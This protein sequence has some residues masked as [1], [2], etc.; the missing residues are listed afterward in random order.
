VFEGRRYVYHRGQWYD[1]GGE[2]LARLHGKIGRILSHRF[3]YALPTWPVTQKLR[4]RTNV[5]YT[6]PVVE[7]HYNLLAA[8]RSNGELVCLDKKLIR[9]EQHPHGIESCDLLGPKNE[10]IHVKRLDDSVSASH[11]FN[12][13]LVSAES[14]RQ[15]DAVQNFRNMVSDV[16]YRTRI[17]PDDFRPSKVVLAFAGRQATPEELFTFSQVSLHRL[18]VRLDVMVPL[19][20]AQI[21]ASEEFV[22]PDELAKL[23]ADGRAS[24]DS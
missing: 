7:G 20:I 1:I 17:I 16:S 8:S 4:K 19:E 22:D 10:L 21:D 23:E 2:Y 18:A 11:L 9:S 3:D 12:Q 14:L 13:A 5:P 15:V 24:G 6:D